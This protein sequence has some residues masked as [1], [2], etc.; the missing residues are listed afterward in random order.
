MAYSKR[1]TTPLG[2]KGSDPLDGHVLTMNLTLR[3]GSDPLDS[4]HRMVHTGAEVSYVDQDLEKRDPTG[5]AGL[6]GG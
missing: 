2:V 3:V 6:V 1:Y 4:V 5:G